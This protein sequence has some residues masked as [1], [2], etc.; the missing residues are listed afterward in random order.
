V[1]RPA[2]RGESIE[3]FRADAEWLDYSVELLDQAETLLFGGAPFTGME[4]YW[5]SAEGPVADRMNALDKVGFSHTARETDWPNAR[6]ATDPVA[7]VA[8]CGAR[9][10]GAARGWDSRGPSGE[11]PRRAGPRRHPSIRLGHRRDELR[12]EATPANRRFATR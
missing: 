8:S 5:P 7:S 11:C 3:W 2:H 10:P 1:R 9:T 4:P 6:V 12:P